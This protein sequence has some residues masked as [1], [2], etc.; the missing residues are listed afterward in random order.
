MFNRVFSSSSFFPLHISTSSETTKTFQISFDDGN[1]R[2]H[3]RV[4]ES[5]KVQ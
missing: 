3:E 1:T 4:V 5:W 2:E